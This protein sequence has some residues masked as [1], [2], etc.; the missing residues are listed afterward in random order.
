MP[1]VRTSITERCCI[2][3]AIPCISMARI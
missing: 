1:D 2:I 3:P